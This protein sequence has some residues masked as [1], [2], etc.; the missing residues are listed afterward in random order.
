MRGREKGNGEEK[1]K[2]DFEAKR[3]GMRRSSPDGREES[4]EVETT[5]R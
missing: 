1:G 3:R 2:E 5:L 4:D